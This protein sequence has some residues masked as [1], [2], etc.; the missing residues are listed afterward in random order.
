MESQERGGFG[1]QEYAHTQPLERGFLDR[2][3]LLDAFH[4]DPDIDDKEQLAVVHALLDH[5]VL[6]ARIACE[7]SQEKPGAVDYARVQ[8]DLAVSLREIDDTLDS[9][10]DSSSDE[11][12]AMP[13]ARPDHVLLGVPRAPLVDALTQPVQEA[14]REPMYND[15]HDRLHNS[16]SSELKQPILDA[17]VASLPALLVPALVPLLQDDLRRGLLPDLQ[18]ALSASLLDDLN[19]RSSLSAHMPATVNAPPMS[20]SPND[21]LSMSSGFRTPSP[22]VG[23]SR[24]TRGSMEVPHSGS[25]ANK[26]SNDGAP[27]RKQARFE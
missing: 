24:Y 6:A 22:V 21:P 20:G 16:L 12:L 10:A 27:V 13:V 25:A 11:E 2:A 1:K 4:L 17:L 8:K 7:V 3:F 14:L 23:R 19:A 26:R 5:A 18:R 15:L 9:G